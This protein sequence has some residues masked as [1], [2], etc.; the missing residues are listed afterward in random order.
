MYQRKLD[1]ND[2]DKNTE[3]TVRNILHMQGAAEMLLCIMKK[4]TFMANKSTAVNKTNNH[5]SHQIIEHKK[6]TKYGFWKP[7]PVLG[8]SSFVVK[9]RS[10]PVIT[11]NV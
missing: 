2:K 4:R 1:K 5:F 8:K 7:V 9:F 11:V 3:L 6:A 10:H